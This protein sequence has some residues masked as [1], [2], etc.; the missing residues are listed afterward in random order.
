M[1]K[2]I[3]YS[4]EKIE[5]YLNLFFKGKKENLFDILRRGK[6]VDT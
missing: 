2:E 4:N 1:E 6:N 5:F 3:L